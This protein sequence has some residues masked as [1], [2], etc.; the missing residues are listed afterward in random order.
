LCKNINLIKQIT[1]KSREKYNYLPLYCPCVEILCLNP[2][3]VL[4][5]EE[6]GLQIAREFDTATFNCFSSVFSLVITHHESR[7]SKKHRQ[8]HEEVPAHSR[9]DRAQRTIAASDLYGSRPF[10]LV[11]AQRHL[12]KRVHDDGSP[13]DPIAGRKG[14]EMLPKST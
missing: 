8:V 6:K 3:K 13:L 12:P 2:F 4:V 10:E 14:F 9:P 7:P 5:S 1:P 11:F